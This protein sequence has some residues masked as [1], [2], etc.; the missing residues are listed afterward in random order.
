MERKTG[1]MVWRCTQAGKVLEVVRT[2][3]PSLPQATVVGESFFNLLPRSSRE[4]AE[5]WWQDLSDN[6]RLLPEIMLGE[7]PDQQSFTVGATVSQQEVWLFWNTAPLLPNA[8]NAP[9]SASQDQQKQEWEPDSQHV[10]LL[11]ELSRVNNELVNARREL[12][13]QNIELH[14]AHKKA[15]P[16]KEMP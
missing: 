15:S 4:L 6:T 8:E 14:R 2:D 7:G 5:Q 10:E 11:E 3:F 1:G 12:I 9:S 16:P 13:R